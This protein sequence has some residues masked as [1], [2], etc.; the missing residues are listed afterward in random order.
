MSSR[1]LQNDLT[2]S[3]S[4]YHVPGTPIVLRPS[5]DFQPDAPPP[6]PLDPLEMYRTIA[7]AT[8]TVCAHGGTALIPQDYHVSGPH[9]VISTQTLPSMISTFRVLC[10]VLRGLAEL[11]TER[12]LYQE[13]EVEVIFG[14]AR[15]ANVVI[16][17][18]GG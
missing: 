14:G 17:R 11:I 7:S 12:N 13:M 4:P 8:K 9:V 10:D 6:T 5:R 2:E 1:Q 3:T 18:R 16:Q 15:T